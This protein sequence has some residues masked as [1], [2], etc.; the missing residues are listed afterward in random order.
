L[1]EPSITGE[2]PGIFPEDTF[3]KVLEGGVAVDIVGDDPGPVVITAVA[4]GPLFE[5]LEL[6]G[7]VA[8]VVPAVAPTPFPLILEIAIE[9]ASQWPLC[10]FLAG[11][12]VDHKESE[13]SELSK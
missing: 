4:D 7:G 3:V 9:G 13:A 6:A 2:M 1:F 11:G 5:P 8:S 10:G 12:I